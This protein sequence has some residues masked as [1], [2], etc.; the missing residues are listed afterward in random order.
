[1]GGWFAIGS[2]FTLALHRKKD[3]MLCHSL[4]FAFVTELIGKDHATIDLR[5]LD[6]FYC[7]ERL[8][9]ER[10]SYPG[11]SDEIHQVYPIRFSRK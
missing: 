10:R 9:S 7:V 1:M 6:E 2:S 5:A 8:P 3:S 11:E 4:Y